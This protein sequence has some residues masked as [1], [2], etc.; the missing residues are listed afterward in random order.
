MKTE[1][2]RHI[3]DGGVLNE[4][5]TNFAHPNVLVEA[6]R[7]RSFRIILGVEKETVSLG[8]SLH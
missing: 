5:G 1:I 2:V 6:M 8:K 4:D 7:T 3:F